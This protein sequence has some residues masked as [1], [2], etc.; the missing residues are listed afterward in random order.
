MPCPSTS[1]SEVAYG[2]QIF[3]PKDKEIRAKWKEGEEMHG[4]VNSQKCMPQVSTQQEGKPHSKFWT[5]W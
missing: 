4:E 2:N 1:K 3:P 5:L